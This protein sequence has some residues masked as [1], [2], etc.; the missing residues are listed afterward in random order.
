MHAVDLARGDLLQL[1]AYPG[2]RLFSTLDR[3][4]EWRRVDMDAAVGDLRIEHPQRLL[5]AVEE[6]D[7]FVKLAFDG[8]VLAAIVN[9]LLSAFLVIEPVHLLWIFAVPRLPGSGHLQ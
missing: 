6:S 7:A 2:L 3:G 9:K 5:V 8:H 4:V 1:G